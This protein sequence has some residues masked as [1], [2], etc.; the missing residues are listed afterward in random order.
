MPSNILLLGAGFSRNWGGSLA[1]EL[2]TDIGLTLE[3]N[4][5]LSAYLNRYDNFEDALAALQNEF[6]R[7]Q[8]PNTI[9]Y[10]LREFQQAIIKTFDSMNHAMSRAPFE[11]SNQSK[12]SVASYLN[13]FDAIFSL[14]QDLLLERHYLATSMIVSHGNPKHHSREIPGMIPEVNPQYHGDNQALH[15]RW[16]QNQPFVCSAGFQPYFKLHGSTNWSS[17]HGEPLMV[18]GGGKSTTIVG[19]PVLM[20]YRQKFKEYLSADGARLTVI[21]YGFRD[22][23]INDAIRDAWTISKF[24]MMIVVGPEGRGILKKVN[25]SYGGAIPGPPGPLEEI[26][27]YD[28]I[29]K[30]ASTFGGKDPAELDRLIRFLRPS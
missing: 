1:S 13:R 5:E 21:G 20:W 22:T 24:P 9:A 6:M 15:T 18:M 10:G 2:R 14:N 25:P 12:Y 17:P 11:F 29:R 8:S 27:C 7:S 23:H 4:R 28:S 30:L 16:R 26:T 3:D 19:H